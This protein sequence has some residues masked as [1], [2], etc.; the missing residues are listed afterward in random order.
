MRL[1]SGW[2]RVFYFSFVAHLA[3]LFILIFTPLVRP[4][5]KIIEFKL[6]P[7]MEMVPAVPEVKKIPEPEVVEKT[8]ALPEKPQAPKKE[9]VIPKKPKAKPKPK[10]KPKKKKKVVEKKAKPK[11]IKKKKKVISKEKL[12]KKLENKLKAIDK[13]VSKKPSRASGVVTTQYFPHQ[14]Y[15]VGLQNKIKEAWEIPGHLAREKAHVFVTFT[16][17]RNGSVTNVHLKSPSGKQLF[18]Q[19]ALAAVQSAQPFPGL[20]DEYKESVLEVTI[21]FELDQ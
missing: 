5:P 6:I 21:R 7:P 11:K 20:P 16:V 15:L 13:Q 18:D 8:S 10:V 4:K 2:G 1:K 19:S 12:R 17:N 9:I 14:W 3:L